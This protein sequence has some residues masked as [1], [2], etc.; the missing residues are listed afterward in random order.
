MRSVD[1]EGCK[2][3]HEMDDI[4]CFLFIQSGNE[5]CFS[6]HLELLSIYFNLASTEFWQQ[7]FV[8]N[9]DTHR[10]SFSCI[11]SLNENSI[12]EGDNSLSNS[13]N[14]RHGDRVEGLK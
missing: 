4:D 5:I 8:S 14:N 12:K 7:N 1:E 3:F 2:S 10:D 9:S 13:R 6:E 11:S